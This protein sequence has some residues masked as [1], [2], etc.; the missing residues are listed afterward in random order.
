MLQQNLEKISK[1]LLY[2][3]LD[4]EWEA[5]CPTAHSKGGT[6]DGRETAF[7]A[8]RVGWVSTTCVPFVAR[9][10]NQHKVKRCN[11]KGAADGQRVSRSLQSLSRAPRVPAQALLTTAHPAF[12]H[13]EV[14]EPCA[15]CSQGSTRRHIPP[16]NRPH[17][18]SMLLAKQVSFGINI[19]ISAELNNQWRVNLSLLLPGMM[20]TWF[21][22]NILAN[23]WIWLSKR[24]TGCTLSGLSTGS[25]DLLSRLFG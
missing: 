12:A 25:V 5:R 16:F 14:P 3:A 20:L 17:P 9:G 23:R 4:W 8:G 10:I 15:G 22:K 1:P 18:E 2:K 13:A 19:K 6:S 7:T 21:L 11:I 24:C